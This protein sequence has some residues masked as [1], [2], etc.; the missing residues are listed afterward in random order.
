MSKVIQNFKWLGT[1]MFFIAGILLSSNI[2][3]SKWGFI[4]FL[5]A[6]VMYVIIFIKEN[7]PPMVAN[8][9]LF[10][11]IDMWGIYRWWFV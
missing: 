1:A 5:T 2:E 3:I 4:I 6:H 8:N 9:V 10:A 7:D 11:G